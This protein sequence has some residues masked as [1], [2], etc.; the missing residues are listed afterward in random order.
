MMTIRQKH[1]RTW[2]SVA[3]LLGMLFSAPYVAWADAPVTRGSQRA[4]VGSVTERA[5][6]T[7]V[8]PLP[9]LGTLL[10]PAESEPNYPA[11]A[12]VQ[13]FTL[14]APLTQDDSGGG[15]WVSRVL[16]PGNWIMDA[17][18]GISTGLLATMSDI[19]LTTV[20]HLIDAPGGCIGVVF[21]T[22]EDTLFDSAGVIS[23][24]LATVWGRLIPVAAML[25]TCFFVVRV[26][27]IAMA[28]PHHFGTEGRN[29]VFMMIAA[30]VL[31]TQSGPFLRALVTFF[32]AMNGA[33]LASD[34]SRLLNLIG[35]KPPLNFGVI[36]TQLIFFL[37]FLCLLF[38]GYIR[39]FKLFLLF[40][41]APLMGAL[42]MIPTHASYFK[43]WVNT[44]L[45]LLV[46]QTIWVVAFMIGITLAMPGGTIP[47]ISDPANNA[48]TIRHFVGAT[49]A[50]LIALCSR[51][52]LSGVFHAVAPAGAT[53]GMFRSLAAW[54][55]VRRAV[56]QSWH[57]RSNRS[58][59]ESQG[60][61]DGTHGQPASANGS[62]GASGGGNAGRS[63]HKAGGAVDA[64][65]SATGAGGAGTSAGGGIRG[66][67]ASVVAA[68]KGIQRVGG[69]EDGQIMPGTRARIALGQR[70]RELNPVPAAPIVRQANV[71][72]PTPA[73]PVRSAGGARIYP[74]GTAPRRHPGAP[75]ILDVQPLPGNTSSAP[76]SPRP[77]L[78]SAYGRDGAAGSEQRALPA[79]AGA[80]ATSNERLSTQRR[81]RQ[82]Q[83][84]TRPGAAT[85]ARS[86]RSAPA[87]KTSQRPAAIGRR[88]RG[89]SLGYA[90]A[91]VAQPG[92]VQRR[93]IVNRHPRQG[94]QPRPDRPAATRTT[95]QQRQALEEPVTLPLSS[96]PAPADAQETGTRYRPRTETVRMHR[97]PRIGRSHRSMPAATQQLRAG[98]SRS[99]YAERARAVQ[100]AMQQSRS[101][102]LRSELRPE[103]A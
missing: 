62:T 60:T 74:P 5:L 103:D 58:A 55:L 79:P 93:A 97:P 10:S 1:T 100:R 69:D 31:I 66:A 12:T 82:E 88:M 23:V 101:E 25:L 7:D 49:I 53:F 36:L 102:Q 41:V 78:P 84:V 20:Q 8:Q 39:L 76:A 70:G 19:V 85:A 98:S 30:L 22:P 83:I 38:V 47:D 86:R 40:A 33:V 94:W 21:C 44:I 57:A 73:T 75:I 92:D 68:G 63:R 28:G 18:M 13:T 35:S 46:Q 34:G 16:N 64:A 77:L 56:G 32:N 43:N 15:S 4:S 27:Q 45:A 11:G 52:L 89:A 29:L 54:Q 72:Q 37:V 61:A 24:S 26:G 9:A 65:L 91:G 17:G 42:L 6:W 48:E 96:T 14:P 80:P 67:T 99:M 81:R 51:S 95:M 90:G 50:I 71:R 59:R 87:R 3:L 2:M